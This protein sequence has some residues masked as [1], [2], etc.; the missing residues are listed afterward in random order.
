MSAESVKSF[1]DL[2]AY[3]V[4]RE[5][6]VFIFNEISPLLISSKEFDLL[7]QLKRAS[8]STTANISEGYG[9]FHYLDNPRFCSIARGSLYESLKHLITAHDENLI[10]D[11]LLQK[12]RDLHIPAM[13]LLNGYFNYPLRAANKTKQAEPK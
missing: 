4:C 2:E 11:E 12:S 8:R 1:E 6:R 7:N 3:K 9:R 5:F 13:A 10:S